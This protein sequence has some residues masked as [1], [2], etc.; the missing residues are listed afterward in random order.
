MKKASRLGSVARMCLSRLVRIDSASSHSISRNSPAP[1]SPVR[2][3]GLRSLAGEYWVM[4]PAE[5]L[6]QMIPRFTGW[7]RLPSRK[8]SFSSLRCTLMPQRQAHI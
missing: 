6:A 8:R 1:R 2:S 4:M 7:R 5:P 3:N